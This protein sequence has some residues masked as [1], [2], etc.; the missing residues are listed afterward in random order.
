MKADS[1]EN[2]IDALFQREQLYLRLASGL[3]AVKI[4]A[5]LEDKTLPPARPRSSS[6]DPGPASL[7]RTGEEGWSCRPRARTGLGVKSPAGAG[8]DGAGDGRANEQD[9]EKPRH[10]HRH[11]ERHVDPGRCGDDCDRIGAAR[12]HG[13]IGGERIDMGEMRQCRGQSAA[14][15][16]QAENRGRQRGE[17]PGG[18]DQDRPVEPGRR[19]S[20][21]RCNR[22]APGARAAT[23]PS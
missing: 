13:Q 3:S 9:K 10:L 23:Q 2:R 12:A 6:R 7:A 19:C 21:R 15:G 22:P 4:S 17:G 8:R 1:L 16:D 11:D 18:V 20:S 5:Q 14:N